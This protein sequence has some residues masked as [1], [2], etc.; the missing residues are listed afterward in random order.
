MQSVTWLK[1]K[2]KMRSGRFLPRAAFCQ[3]WVLSRN[4]HGFV[5][6]NKI[7]DLFEANLQQDKLQ[8]VCQ[9]KSPTL[10]P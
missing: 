5:F 1:N 7:T 3:N 4:L 6:F 2:W 9:K 10:P 8:Y